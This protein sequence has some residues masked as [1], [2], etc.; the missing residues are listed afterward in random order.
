MGVHVREKRAGSSEFWV[1][2]ASKG[3]RTSRLVGDREAAETAAKMIQAKLTLGDRS[4]F[5]P[6]APL[7]AKPAPVSARSRSGVRPRMAENPRAWGASPD[8]PGGT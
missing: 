6:P 7:A 1:F 3:Q 4:I 8:N 2:V 5:D